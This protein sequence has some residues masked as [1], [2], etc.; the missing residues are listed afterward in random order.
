LNL[1]SLTHGKKS[2]ALEALKLQHYALAR[3]D[4][5]GGAGPDG[6]QH[7]LQHDEHSN[8][9]SHLANN[10]F[11]KLHIRVIAL[12]NLFIALLAEG[13]E[14]QTERALEMANVIAPQSGFTRHPLTI[15]AA[16]HMHNL[17][18]RA[19]KLK[20][21]DTQTGSVSGRKLHGES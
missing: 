5:E 18:E 13:S 7:Q 21:S 6:P 10:D 12:E 20:A 17:V 11:F 15:H 3:W 8:D 19:T 4:S 1:A 14:K 16:R 2:D 9:V